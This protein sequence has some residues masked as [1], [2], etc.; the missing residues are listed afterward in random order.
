MKVSKA[1]ILK[2]DTPVSNEYAKICADSCD[3]IGLDWKYYNGFQNMTG[4][5]AFGKL[6][7]SGLPTE[8]YQ[9]IHNPHQAHKAMCATAGHFGIWKAISEGPDEAA[10]ILEHDAIMLQPINIDIPDNKIV[11][12]GYKLQDPSRY[13]HKDAGEPKEL[14]SIDGHEGAHAYAIT[15]N[16]AKFLI[17]EIAEKGIRSAIDNDYFIRG[18]RKTAIPLVIASPT[19]AMGWL[20]EST[21][22]NSSANKNYAFIPSFQQNYK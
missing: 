16:T 2:I 1:Y 3:K 11:V 10:V 9:Q 14:I 13:N 21:I 22:W 8:P 5:M 15:K 19:P 17:N 20:R 7:I 12:L 18:Q 4:K 6:G